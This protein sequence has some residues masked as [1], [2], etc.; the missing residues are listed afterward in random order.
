[1][2]AL[3][4]RVGSLDGD[5][6][7]G[8]GRRRSPGGHALERL[9]IGREVGQRVQHVP[10]ELI[11]ESGPGAVALAV[12]S[13]GMKV[14]HHVRRV[15]HFRAA[16]LPLPIFWVTV[17]HMRH[18]VD[19]SGH[20]LAEPVRRLKSW[21]NEDKISR[22]SGY[23]IQTSGYS[24]VTH[25]HLI[26]NRTAKEDVQS[27]HV[28]AIKDPRNT[29]IVA[30]HRSNEAHRLVRHSSNHDRDLVEVSRAEG[31][32]RV[33][34]KEGTIESGLEGQLLDDASPSEIVG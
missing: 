10:G 29:W 4:K 15:A 7:V 1:M 34:Q 5:V 26:S 19:I 14:E 13:D 11:L 32:P 17:G 22:G 8:D 28:E 33:L 31:V 20:I 2:T 9:R 30:F 25:S 16:E 27:P 12:H 3:K 23:G 21:A 24:G 18:L 6:K